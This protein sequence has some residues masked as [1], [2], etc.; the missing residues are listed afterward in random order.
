M[1]RCK[2]LVQRGLFSSPKRTLHTYARITRKPKTRITF[3]VSHENRTERQGEPKLNLHY[4]RKIR[5]LASLNVFGDSPLVFIP[6]A[7]AVKYL[8]DLL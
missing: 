3:G 6:K 7:S 2:E 4:V 5:H 1:S 8:L